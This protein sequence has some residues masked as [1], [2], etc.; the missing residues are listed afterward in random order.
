M[1]NPEE[2]LADCHALLQ[3]LEEEFKGSA[4]V[5]I[6]RLYYDAFQ[7]SISHGNKAHASAF[8]DRDIDQE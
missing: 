7:I 6:A 2:S 3:V 1:R 4:G 5:L 8:A